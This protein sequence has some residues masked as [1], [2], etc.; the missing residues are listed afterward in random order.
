MENKWTIGNV[1]YMV[2][3]LVLVLAMLFA[4]VKVAVAQDQ[5]PVAIPQERT[6]NAQDRE[7]LAAADPVD[8]QL[9]RYSRL[10]PELGFLRIYK[11]NGNSNGEAIVNRL[12]ALLGNDAVD[13]DY[14]H[15]ETQNRDVVDLQFYRIAKMVEQGLPSATLFKLGADSVFDHR[16]LCV[17]T[18]D[19]RPFRRDPAYAT[20]FMTSDIEPG[21]SVNRNEPYIRNE[22]FLRF[23]VDH[24]AFHCLDAY[25]N[26]APF[27]KTSDPLTSHYDHY[28]SE[29]RAD[30]YAS[31]MF[32]LVRGHKKD[33]LAR[34]ATLRTQSL[35]ATDTF[36]VSSDVIVAAARVCLAVDRLE[37][38]EVINIATKLV[39]QTVPGLADYGEYM[40][41][42]VAAIDRIGGSAREVMQAYEL[43]SLPQPDEISVA[44]LVEQVKTGRRLINE[45]DFLVAIVESNQS[46][47]KDQND[48]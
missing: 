27:R 9:A 3:A 14:E 35:A 19:T 22:D 1:V 42:V 26:G 24:E 23:T 38:E 30:A 10:I 41:N 40:A 48:S 6:F 2:N 28:L 37:P 20:S 4:G 47:E 43:D 25:F 21:L 17:V 34:L 5:R 31:L 32:N 15:D 8:R 39:D 33:F 13:M 29:M 46:L 7:R 45:D 12:P 16:Y 11:T 36:H 18:L 44:A